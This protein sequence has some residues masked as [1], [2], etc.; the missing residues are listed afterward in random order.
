MAGSGGRALLGGVI[1]GL[2]NAFPIFVRQIRPFPRHP[3]HLVY[4]QQRRT[5]LYRRRRLYSTGRMAPQYHDLAV[6]N[7]AGIPTPVVI[8]LALWLAAWLITER[9]LVRQHA[10]YWSE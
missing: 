10:R 6:G 8:V 4:R 3:R 2:L 5:H 1:I 9:P 7:I